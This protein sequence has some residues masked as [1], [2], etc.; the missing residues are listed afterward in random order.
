[1]SYDNNMTGILRRNDKQGNDQRPDYKGSVE[2]EGQK[3]WLSAWIRT[4]KEG[5]KLAGEKYMSLKLEPAEQQ[6]PR[7]APQQDPRQAPRQHKPSVQVNA[8]WEEDADIPF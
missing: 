6:A 1:M 3:F 5:T 4:G 7:Q 2:I 8:N